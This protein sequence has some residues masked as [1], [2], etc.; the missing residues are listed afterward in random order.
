MT[1]VY[2]HADIDYVVLY[3]C[4]CVQYFLFQLLSDRDPAATWLAD[5]CFP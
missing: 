4:V 1:R 3:R 2:R 5:W